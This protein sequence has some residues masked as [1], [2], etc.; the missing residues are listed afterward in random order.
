MEPTKAPIIVGIAK[1]IVFLVSINF[2]CLNI[3]VALK[4]WIKT[5]ILL[6]ALALLAGIPKAKNRAID[7][8]VP[9]AER[10][11]IK[12]TNIPVTT[13]IT[14]SVM[15]IPELFCKNTL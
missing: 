7:I 4:D 14:I 1:R 11:L 2:F 3:R 15:L 6:V 8:T 9:P 13:R 12:P 5:C 10:V